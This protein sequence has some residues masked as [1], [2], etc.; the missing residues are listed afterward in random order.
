MNQLTM[1]E[2]TGKEVFQIAERKEKEAQRFLERSDNLELRGWRRAAQAEFNRA[3]DAFDQA[4]QMN[5]LAEFE[6]L[7]GVA[8]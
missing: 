1:F 8:Q 4:E 7:G 3:M 2:P 6:A 5:M